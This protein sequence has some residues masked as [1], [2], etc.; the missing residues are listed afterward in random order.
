MK[1]QASPDTLVTITVDKEGLETM[2]NSA[3]YA[4]THLNEW[5]FGDEYDTNIT[6]YHELLQSLKEKYAQVYGEI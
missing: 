3:S 1:I 4:I 2:I 5:N 6:P